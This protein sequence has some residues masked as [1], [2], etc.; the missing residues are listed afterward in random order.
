MRARYASDAID[1]DDFR[2]S[3]PRHPRCSWVRPS[4]GARSKGPL[5]FGECFGLRTRPLID[6]D[7]V[8][9]FVYT[10]RDPR[11]FIDLRRMYGN[12]TDLAGTAIWFQ[13]GET[14]IECVEVIPVFDVLDVS[15]ELRIGE[16]LKSECVFDHPADMHH[17]AQVLVR[18]DLTYRDDDDEEAW[19]LLVALDEQDASVEPMLQRLRSG[20][21]FHQ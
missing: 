12:G 6:N 17:F 21:A 5:P 3:L 11:V 20:A 15:S 14:S 18:L 10:V 16:R 2:R 9:I 8:D 1:F 19:V 4:V 13:D 7:S